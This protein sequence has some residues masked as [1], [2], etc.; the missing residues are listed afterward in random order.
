M[1]DR[2]PTLSQIAS[3]I[4]HV[5]DNI[6]RAR[7]RF[8]LWRTFTRGQIK[9]G[10]EYLDAS[11]T[12]FHLCRP[13]MYKGDKVMVRNTFKRAKDAKA[14][15][16]PSN[17][18]KFQRLRDAKQF[19][20]LCKETFEVVTDTSRRLLGDSLLRTSDGTDPPDEPDDGT[21]PPAGVPPTTPG[22]LDRPQPH[23]LRTNS[24]AAATSSTG[25]QIQGTHMAT[26]SSG[27]AGIGR[28]MDKVSEAFHDQNSASSETSV[29]SYKTERTVNS[30][31]SRYNALPRRKH[32]DSGHLGVTEGIASLNVD[33][34]SVQG[35]EVPT[36]GPPPGPPPDQMTDRAQEADC[37]SRI[38]SEGQGLLL[39][40]EAS[41]DD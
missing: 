35:G 4:T 19:K 32:A 2:P 28:P 31:K 7:R 23:D 8:G 24:H 37:A 6:A 18:S 33:D 20:S 21:D 39:G 36:A 14:R 1:T 13:L 10:E 30:R 26:L 34:A 29:A 22:E 38:S 11:H 27:A 17:V 12:I 40:S 9:R 41:A 5:T 25:G 16:K 15:L 3:T